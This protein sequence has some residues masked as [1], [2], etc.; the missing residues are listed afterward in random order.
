VPIKAILAST[1]H[2]RALLT[3]PELEFRRSL[4][5]ERGSNGRASHDHRRLANLATPRPVRPSG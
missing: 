5:R 4:P 2:P 3:Q 1:V